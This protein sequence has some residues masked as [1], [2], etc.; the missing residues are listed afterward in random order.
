MKRDTTDQ[1][2]FECRYDAKVFL[3]IS[4]GGFLYGEDY[5]GEGVVRFNEE[6]CNQNVRIV[7][8]LCFFFSLS[9]VFIL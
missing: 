9:V 7:L 3:K 6:Y 5:L 2:D 8:V 4:A 1:I